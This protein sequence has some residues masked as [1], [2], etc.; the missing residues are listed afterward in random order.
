M[1]SR[2]LHRLRHALAGEGEGDREGQGGGGSEAEEFPE[3]SELEDDTD[4]LSTRLSGTLS[5][6]SNEEEEEE[7]NEEDAASRE[8]GLPKNPGA[9]ENGGRC[10]GPLVTRVW[11]GGAG[12]AKT[13]FCWGGDGGSVIP[14]ALA[15]PSHGPLVLG[16]V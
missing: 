1:A 6:T 9:M 16:A 8:L 4:G 2:L 5:F 11:D 13:L 14:V 10:Q 12:P 15:R 3:S 7:E